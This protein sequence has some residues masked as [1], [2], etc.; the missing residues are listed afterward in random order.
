MT[1]T[2]HDRRREVYYSSQGH[3][4]WHRGQTNPTD[5]AQHVMPKAEVEIGIAEMIET[6]IPHAQPLKLIVYMQRYNA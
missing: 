5:R 2:L 6:L 3:V 1:K 4:G